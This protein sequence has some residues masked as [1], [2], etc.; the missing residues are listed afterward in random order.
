MNALV[1]CHVSVGSVPIRCTPIPAFKFLEA[2]LQGSLENGR[3]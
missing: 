1:E 3:R 2:E